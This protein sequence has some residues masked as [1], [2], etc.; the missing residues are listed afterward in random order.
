VAGRLA[1][2]SLELGGKN[3][4]YVADDADLD[5]AVEGATRACFSSAGQ[6]CIS[7]ERLM[8]HDAVADEFTRRFVEAVSAMRLGPELAYGTD[9]GSLVSADQLARVTAHV[10]DARAKGARV[11]AGGR[12]RPELGPFFYEPTI[13]SGVTP[14]MTVCAAETFGPVVSIYPVRSDDD[15]VRLA[16]S[17]E[18]GL[19][20]SVYTRDVARGRRIGAAIQ[21]G[22]VNVNEAYGAAWGSVA[23]PMGGM[24]QSGVGRRHG[25]E[26]ILKYTES[27]NVT[28]QYLM[29]I[30]PAFGLSEE[31]YVRA[32]TSA[33]R[34]LKAVGRR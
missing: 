32:M 34:V 11:L 18:Y 20:A 29:P 22:T 19:N 9:M 8:V 15:A 10:E 31:A 16:N 4:M 13:L 30:A 26:G 7:I 21:A 17:S 3:A 23:A 27:Q 2:Y 25:V 24:K 6:L 1:G 5:R 33:L 28:A 12:A 14:D